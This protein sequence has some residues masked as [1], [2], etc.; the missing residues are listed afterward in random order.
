MKSINKNS[1]MDL[2]ASAAIDNPDLPI[3]FINDL[4]AVKSEKNPKL[5]PFVPELYEPAKPHKAI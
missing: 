5:E 3:E 2:V 4:L 1:F